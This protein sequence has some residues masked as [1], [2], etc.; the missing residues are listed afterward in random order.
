MKNL[1]AKLIIFSLVLTSFGCN[2]TS[3]KIIVKKKIESLN[4]SSITGTIS[5]TQENDSVYLEAHVFG[6]DPGAK[7][8]HI[9]EIGDC[10]SDDGSS[11]GGHWNPYNTK[12][13]K[14]GDPTGF[15]LGAVGNFEVDSIGHGMLNFKTDLWCI[16]CEEENDIIN[17]AVIIHQ[18]SDDYVSQPSGASG[19]RIGC[20]EINIPDDVSL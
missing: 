15:H 13:S 18:G 11:T 20:M 14:W 1:T 10:S 4:N 19:I 5:F 9:H 17:K 16:G 6:L 3:E 12:H 8:L 7:A 2:Q